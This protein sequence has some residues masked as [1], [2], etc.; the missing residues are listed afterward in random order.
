VERPMMRR[1]ANP[2]RVDQAAAAEAD[3]VP[4]GQLH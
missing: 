3:L 4:A 1:F 2:K